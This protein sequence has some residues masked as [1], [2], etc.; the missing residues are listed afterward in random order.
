VNFVVRNPDF[1]SLT[2]GM[3]VMLARA[4][5]IPGLVNVDTDL[6]VNKPELNVSYNRDRAEDL[7]IGV[8]DVSSTLQ[9]M[10]GGQRVGTFTR[11]SK[12]YYVVLQ[13]EDTDR[14]T[15]SD[16]T[17]LYIRGRDG[18]EVK[19]DALA[20]IDES[21]G[22]TSLNHYD[23]VRSFTLSAGLAP[24]YTL[25]AAIDD[26]EALADEVLPRGSSTAL[27]GES[28]ELEETGNALYFAFVLALIVVYMVLAA[29]FESLVHP[30]TVLLSVPLAVTGA[31]MTLLVTGSSLNLFSQIGMILLVGLAT[32]NSI[33]L[34]EYANQLR[35]RGLETTEAVLEAGR[36]RLRPILMT[37]VATIVAMFP[38]ALGLGAGSA[39]RRPLGYA[40]IGGMVFATVLT[41]F[42]VPV[43]YVIFDS[44]GE[45]FRR[46]REG[47]SPVTAEG[48]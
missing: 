27:S 43:V 28:R 5:Q 32:K 13:L 39:S 34:V 44:L 47:L 36:I 30:F 46:R 21:V 6:K 38:I 25:G 24:G 2:A 23:R 26:L 37:S 16:M 29:Q 3:D 18:S 8:A 9:T 22:P 33:L 35:E 48:Q 41:L 31:L 42:L 15:P 20:S 12:L 14:A 17:D 40:I 11:D 1:D 19:L 4:R 45:R 10:L 7:G